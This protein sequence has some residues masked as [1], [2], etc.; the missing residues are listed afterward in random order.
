MIKLT[1]C[2]A[3]GGIIE[4][5]TTCDPIILDKLI[6][7]V[8]QCWAEERGE[9]NGLKPLIFQGETWDDIA[10]AIIAFLM[11]DI[12]AWLVCNCHKILKVLKPNL[13]LQTRVKILLLLQI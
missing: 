4:S 8:K 7:H 3:C 6:E 5:M 2:E 11:E 9:T 10:N 1:I 13:S 12:R